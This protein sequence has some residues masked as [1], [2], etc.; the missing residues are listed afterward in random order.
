ME[1]KEEPMYEVPQSWLEGLAERAERVNKQLDQ[2]P[3]EAFNHLI[4]TDIS[5]LTGYASS[6]R[7]LI[8]Y[9][10]IA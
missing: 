2:L 3:P 1:T 4:K 10:R 9:R 6:A 7:T 5:G 8:K